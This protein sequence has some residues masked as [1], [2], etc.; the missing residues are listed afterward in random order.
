MV[1]LVDG[2][3]VVVAFVHLPR[4]EVVVLC[5]AALCRVVW[6]RWKEGVRFVGRFR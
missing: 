1:G 5:V 2:G 6:K 4:S 3:Q